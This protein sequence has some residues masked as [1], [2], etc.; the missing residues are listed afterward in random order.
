MRAAIFR[1]PRGRSLPEV[2]L[3]GFRLVMDVAPATFRIAAVQGHRKVM[4]SSEPN[5]PAVASRRDAQK[6]RT[7]YGRKARKARGFGK[8]SDLGRVGYRFLPLEGS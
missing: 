3:F 7:G 6:L 2:D 1:A 8:V 4:A 5:L